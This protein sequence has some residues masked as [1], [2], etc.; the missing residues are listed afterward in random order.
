MLM[1][2]RLKKIPFLSYF[3]FL[4]LI[5]FSFSSCSK[6]HPTKPKQ[7][8]QRLLKGNKR[9]VNNKSEHP[10]RCKERRKEIA[11]KQTPYAVIVGCS[12]SRI[13]PEIIFDTGLGDLFV[14]RVAGNVIG[15]IELE[16][17]EYSAVNL[18]SAVIVVLGH[19]NCGAVTAV[20]QN[21][22]TNIPAVAELIDPAVIQAQDAKNTKNKNQLEQAIKINALNMKHLLEQSPNLETLIQKKK[23]QVHAAYYNLKTGLVELLKD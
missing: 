14:V 12:D 6:K 23:I 22:A 11:S 4:L 21:K 8:L 1:Q 20:F 10:N 17:I 15:P 7:A 9:Y 13:V 5:A 19:E 18:N 2:S 3:L 16:S